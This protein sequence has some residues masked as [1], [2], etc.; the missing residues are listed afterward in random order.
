MS[1]IHITLVGGYIAPVYNGIIGTKPDQVIYI[2]STE[3]EKGVDKV[4]N[5]LLRNGYNYPSRRV[6]VD[7][8]NRNEIIEKISKLR[9]MHSDDKVSINISSGTKAWTYHIIKLFADHPDTQFFYVEQ[10][11][12]MQNLN[13][14]ESVEIPF[15]IDAQMR[16]NDIELQYT[17][18][19][20]YTD[21]DIEC[22]EKIRKL[23]AFHPQAFNELT[24]DLTTYANKT[25]SD[26]KDYLS[27]LSWNRENK[28]FEIQLIKKNGQ[29][30]IEILSSPNIRSLLLNTGWFEFEIANYLK[31]W[32]QTREIRMNCRFKA[33]NKADK[34][35]VD[36]LINAGK[37]MLFVEC[38]TKIANIT[39]IDKFRS[40]VRNYG[41]LSSKGIFITDESIEKNE[42]IKAK[43]ADNNMNYFSIKDLD[44]TQPQNIKKQLFRKLDD[45]ISHH[46]IR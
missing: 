17:R 14:D 4:R 42:T 35:E 33:K 11:N 44:N 31:E 5:E 21:A 18:F 27:H 40:V 8:T 13:T 26:T 6:S 45:L 22:I 24:Q 43:M 34:N 30:M 12:L 7:A 9:S 10:N 20:Q 25:I 15:D 28:S 16:L 2:Y 1:H 37:R 29:S 32:S 39:D 23:R 19:G 36:I 46:S 3:T 41:S 38:K